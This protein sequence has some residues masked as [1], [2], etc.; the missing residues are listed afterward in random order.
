MRSHLRLTTSPVARPEAVVQGDRWRISV[1]ADGLVRLEWAEDGAFEDRA[2]TFALHRDLPVPEFTVTEGDSALEVVTD[3]LRLTYDRG[4]FAPA[5]L[6]VQARGDISTHPAV[7][8]LGGPADDLG[9]PPRALDDIDG[10]APL[11]PGVVSRVGV[12]MLDDSGSLC[13]EDDG[14]VSPRPPGGI[15]LYVF[16]YGH[17]YAGA[18]DAF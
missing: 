14:W 1:L 9:G 11:G 4:P 18:L 6:P 8:P 10:R 7:G 5:G 16:A 2:T 17:D 15:D 3:K 12:A 13:F